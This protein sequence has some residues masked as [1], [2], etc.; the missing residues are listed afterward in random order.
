MDSI[1][2]QQ[3]LLMAHHW[4]DPITGNWQLIFSFIFD[5]TTWQKR[6]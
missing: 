3:C 1:G 5:Q 4:D 6:K 2:N